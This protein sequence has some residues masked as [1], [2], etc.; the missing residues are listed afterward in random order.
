[1]SAQKW[2][3]TS[4]AIEKNWC[5]CKCQIELSGEQAT[6]KNSRRIGPGSRQ[7]VEYLCFSNTHSLTE[8]WR[9]RPHLRIHWRASLFSAFFLHCRAKQAKEHTKSQTAKICSFIY[10]WANLVSTYFPSKCDPVF[11]SCSIVTYTFSKAFVGGPERECQLQRS[12]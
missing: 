9:T 8:L 7:A 5:L 2:D 12:T 10:C 6:M 1:M 11:F 4:S 3:K